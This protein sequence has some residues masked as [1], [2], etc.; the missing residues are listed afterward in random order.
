LVISAHASAKFPAKAESSDVA[1]LSGVR[2]S[3]LSD[4]ALCMK[5]TKII[6]YTAISWKGGVAAALLPRQTQLR[7]RTTGLTEI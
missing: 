7:S 1:E 6:S 4:E 2:G 5:T 3:G